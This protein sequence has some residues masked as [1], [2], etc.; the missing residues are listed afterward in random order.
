MIQATLEPLK[1]RVGDTPSTRTQKLELL[2]DRTASRTFMV[3][4]T[5]GLASA[6][7]AEPLLRLNLLD[8]IAIGEIV[9]TA[10]NAATG[11]P[12]FRFK[13]NG[14]DN[15][16]VTFTGTTGTASGIADYAAGDLFEI[17]P[18]LIADATLDDVSISIPVTIG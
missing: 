5:D 3:S 2:R 1:F 11:S 4:I 8:S 6:D 14:A 9:A 16:T 7:P 15:G 10:G 18:P 17:Y 13:K 12:A